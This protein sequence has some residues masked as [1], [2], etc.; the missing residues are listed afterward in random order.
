[1]NKGKGKKL[2]VVDLCGTFVKDDTT[3]GLIDFH[4]SRA[5]KSRWKYLVFKALTIKHS[6][7]RLLIACLEK[8]TSIH[9]LKHIIV[10]LLKGEDV[11]EFNTSAKGYAV[12]LL[13]NRKVERIYAIVQEYAQTHKIVF[14]SASLNPLVSIIAELIGAEYISSSLCEVK[15]KLV[16]E[17]KEDLTGKKYSSLQEMYG[18][19]LDSILDVV[20]SD[21]FSDLSLL[22]KAA[23]PIV[24]LRKPSHRLRWNKFKAMF[25]EDFD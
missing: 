4:L 25:I 1:M 12:F 24:V 11:S 14:A 6:P 16:G 3:I 23:K 22:S 13:K 17:Y 5:S 10:Y 8:F 20:I 18:E 19:E 7:L 21:N 15:G 2:C 9:I